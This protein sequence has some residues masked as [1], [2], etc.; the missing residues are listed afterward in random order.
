MKFHNGRKYTLLAGAALLATSTLVVAENTT[1][2]DADDLVV[3]ASLIESTGGPERINLSGKLRMLSQRIPAASCNMVARIDPETS[4]KIL[5]GATR[6][7]EKILHALEHGD[8]SLGIIGP[9]KRRKTLAAI[10]ALKVDWEPMDEAANW[11]IKN[12]PDP[13]LSQV[14]AD[15]SDALLEEAKVLVSEITGEYSDPAALMQSDALRIDIAGRQRML[16][17]RMSKDACLIMSDLN[18]EAAIG[19]M[20]KTVAMF[21]VSLGALV[22]GMP[23]AGI[24]ASSDP[25]IIAGLDT[26]AQDWTVFKPKLD[27]LAAGES[28]DENARAEMFTGL[29]RLLV[30]MNKVVGL[31]AE[32]SKIGI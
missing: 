28:W 16:S 11:M 3:Q 8:E 12:G 29:N 4:A 22:N 27:A 9:E 13:E 1:S 30:N 6:E 18:K 17:Q 25:A 26:V 15:H 10:E 14:L 19:T 2:L 7:F 32:A 5:A 21:D 20:S 24:K 23:A 31:Y